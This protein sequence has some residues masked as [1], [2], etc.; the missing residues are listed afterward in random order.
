[1]A[2]IFA[3]SFAPSALA[4]SDRIGY[5]DLAQVLTAHPRYQESQKHLDDYVTQRGEEFKKAADAETDPEKR[6]MLLEDARKES[7]EEELRVMNPI[8]KEI[9]DTI[10]KVAQS[11]GIDIVV[12]KQ[13][14]FFGGLDLTADVVKALQALK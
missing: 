13:L 11:K 8:N 2:A 9:N 5:I 10:L 3:A 1:M 4:A 7:G 6:R 12:G 14:V